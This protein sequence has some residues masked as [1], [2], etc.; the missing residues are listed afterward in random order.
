MKKDDINDFNVE[1][2]IRRLIEDESLRSTARR[3]RDMVSAALVSPE[4]QLIGWTEFL[5]KFKNLSQMTPPGAHMSNFVYHSLDVILLFTSIV[6]CGLVIISIIG[7]CMYRCARNN[8][9]YE[10][11]K[12]K[13]NYRES[14]NRNVMILVCLLFS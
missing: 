2:N 3:Y 7:Y 14:R 5:S 4:A 13:A 10:A 1:N 9:R 8:F 6:I 12:D 11:V